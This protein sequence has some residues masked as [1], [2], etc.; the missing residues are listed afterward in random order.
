MNAIAFFDVDHTL[1]DGYSGYH[2]TRIL[3]EKKIVQYRHLLAALFYRAVASYY[4][5]DVYKMYEILLKDL[6]GRSL[7]E[8]MRIGKECFEK[9][10]RPKLF[11]EGEKAIAEHRNLGH[12]IYLL[13]SGPGMVIDHVADFFKVDGARSIGPVVTQGIIQKEVRKPL[14]YQDG[15]SI[16]AQQI[17]KSCGTDLSECYY[18]A[19]SIDDLSLMLRVGHPR[20]VNPDKEIREIAQQNQWPIRYYRQYL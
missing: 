14:C 6:A 9:D 4:K 19:D 10:I 5:G 15:K 13:S 3:V 1:F 8:V 7:E 18:Y 2:A 17:A 16:F 20:P 11:Q 12:K